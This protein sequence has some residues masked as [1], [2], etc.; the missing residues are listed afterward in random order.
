M[1]ELVFWHIT[2]VE[3][4]GD[5][6]QCLDALQ[7]GSRTREEKQQSRGGCRLVVQISLC[8]KTL[9]GGGFWLV[10][11]S[12]RVVLASLKG[13]DKFQ[14]I[15]KLPNRDKTEKLRLRPETRC[16]GNLASCTQ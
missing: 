11:T 7:W 16:Q 9:G 10:L 13:P 6:I 5:V 4:R 1:L 12:S 3:T 8:S 2:E 14:R 15:P